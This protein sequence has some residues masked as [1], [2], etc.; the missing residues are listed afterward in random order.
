MNIIN[1][2]HETLCTG[3]DEAESAPH[4]KLRGATGGARILGLTLLSASAAIQVR[5]GEL[6]QIEVVGVYC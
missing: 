1:S 6:F 4:V 5:N 3:G 2:P